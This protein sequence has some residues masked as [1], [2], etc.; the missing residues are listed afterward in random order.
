MVKSAA[1]KICSTLGPAEIRT[2]E[3]LEMTAAQA[4]QWVDK[5]AKTYID[6]QLRKIAVEDYGRYPHCAYGDKKSEVEKNYQTYATGGKIEHAECSKFANL[7]YGYLINEKCKVDSG[8]PSVVQVGLLPPDASCGHNIVVVNANFAQGGNVTRELTLQALPAAA[9]DWI[10][11]D[12][13][14]SGM[15]HPY[16]DCVFQI[17][18]QFVNNWGPTMQI[19]K[20]WNPEIPMDYLAH[21][22]KK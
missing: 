2:S 5:R 6:K 3:V 14:W 4:K 1:E 13:W 9:A 15:G 16:D 17:N 20:G 8:A 22:K 7:V 21:L 18:Q 12:G 11:V 10:V 19:I